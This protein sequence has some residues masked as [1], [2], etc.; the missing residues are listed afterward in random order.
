MSGGVISVM[1]R[2]KLG[3]GIQSD[4]DGGKVGLVGEGL[5]EEATFE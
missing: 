2:M 4:W 3:K 1:K 5:S